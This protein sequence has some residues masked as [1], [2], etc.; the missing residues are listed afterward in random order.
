MAHEPPNATML[1]QHP[2]DMTT[3]ER[4]AWMRSID[5]MR[6]LEYDLYDTFNL[7]ETFPRAWN[8]IWRGKDRDTKTVRLTIRLD[9]DVVRFFKSMGPGYQPRINKVLRSFM[10]ARLARV[11]GGAEGEV[12]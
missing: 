10:Q 7:N 9:A 11:V 1:G 4:I 3:K 8:Q 12:G 5:G 6:Q 2:R